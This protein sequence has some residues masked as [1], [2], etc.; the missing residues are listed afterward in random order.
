M[1]K[2]I[3]LIL[4]L[5]VIFG[6]LVGC[7]ENREKSTTSSNLNTTQ[8]NTTNDTI[9]ATRII[10][11]MAGIEVEIPS[12]VDA[13]VDS[14]AAHATFDLLLDRYEHMIATA[15]PRNSKDSWVYRIAPNLEKVES[16]EFS[17]NMN[18]EEIIAL[19][20]D[21]VF[22]KAEN[23]REMFKDVGIP[24]VNVGFYSYETMVQ[25][26]HLVA[27]ILG[28]DAMARADKYV[29]YLYNRIDWVTEHLLPLK[30]EDK[31]SIAHGHP[32]YELRIDGDNTIIDEWINYSG[33]TNSAKN[34]EGETVIVSLEE[35]LRWDPDVIISGDG[36]DDVNSV[37]EDPA[38]ASL[39]AVKNGTVYVNPKG[40]FMWDRYGIEEA[41]QI[42]WCAS[43]L[44]PD[45]FE[46]FDIREEVKYFYREFLD[47]ELSDDEVEKFMNHENP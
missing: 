7:S 18:L 28:E 31:L 11:D 26:I 43:T 3:A 40:I 6:L 24:Y 36:W 9:P 17:E 1:K 27:E 5:V 41:L 35:L 25:S 21:V 20:P 19:H 4:V 33:S 39:T 45:L 29:G 13:Y 14:W 12:K 22:G 30:E 44:Y 37:M 10:T 23:Y 47:Y 8:D 34:V 38:W 42:Q 32:L 15:V 16:I 2:G 46:G